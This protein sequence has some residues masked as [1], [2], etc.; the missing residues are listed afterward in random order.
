MIATGIEKQ[1]R[2][3]V[4]SSWGVAPGAT[5]AQ[6]LRRTSSTPDLKKQTF[7]ST[8]LARHKQRV[9]FRHGPKSVE[10][11]IN[12]ELSPGTYEDFLAAAV[13][14]AFTAVTAL[15]TLSLTIAGAGP[16]YTITRATGDWL[17]GG[18]KF[19]QV[20][21]IT[22]GSVNAANLNKNLLILSLTATVLTVMPLNGEALVAEGPIASC[23]WTP[24]GKVSYIPSTGHIDQSFAFEE[25]HADLGKSELFLGCKINQVDIAMPPT[26]MATI[27]LQLLGKDMTPANVEYFT[28]PAAEL[29][30]GILAGANGLLVAQGGA[31]AHVTGLNFSGKGNMS[32][33]PTVGSNVYP[34]IAEGRVLVDGQLTA[35][36]ESVAM[37]DY[38]LNETEVSLIVALSA[39][40]AAAA[41][42]MSFTFPRVKFGGAAKDDGDKSIV[43]T[44][45]FTSL[46]YAAGGAALAQ[47]QTS[48]YVQDSQA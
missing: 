9:D 47:E 12:G 4:E 40:A 22:A 28:T 42:F 43:R 37:R 25:Y 10:G 26:G 5:G 13:R 6:L 2:Y 31:V 44:L 18:I 14:R 41:D 8:E 45:P 23:T 35:L 38:F 46:Y 17:A 34:D 30:T 20:G 11:T 33:E 24:T 48:L 21:R 1:L 16:T 15:T 36:F 19:G 39:S 3:K 32:A 27:A 29:T 7:E